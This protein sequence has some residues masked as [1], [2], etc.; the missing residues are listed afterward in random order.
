MD[1]G[2]FVFPCGDPFGSDQLVGLEQIRGDSQPGIVVAGSDQFFEKTQI[3]VWRF[4]KYLGLIFSLSPFFEVTDG[5]DSFGRFDR[6]VSVDGERLSVL[7]RSHQGQ[8][9]A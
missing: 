8:N 6:E 3:P 1:V 9:D 2:R 4:D 5:P 7:S